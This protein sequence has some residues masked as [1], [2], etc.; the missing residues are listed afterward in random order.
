MVGFILN[1]LLSVDNFE[2][3]SDLNLYINFV[4]L[5]DK[6]E[7]WVVKTYPKAFFIEAPIQGIG[8]DAPHIQQN[9]QGKHKQ[10]QSIFSL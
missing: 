7:L 3:V 1:S 9:V 2:A 5:I 10:N 4:F 8:K 6:K